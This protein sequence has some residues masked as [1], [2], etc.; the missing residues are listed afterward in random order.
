MSVVFQMNKI[1][2]SEIKMKKKIDKEEK[3]EVHRNYSFG[4]IVGDYN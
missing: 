1:K 4:Y 2:K 3:E